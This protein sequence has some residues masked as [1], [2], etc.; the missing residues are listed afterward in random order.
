MIKKIKS[1]KT[2]THFVL[3]IMY[4]IGIVCDFFG[5]LSIGI[6]VAAYL[7]LIGSCGFGIAISIIWYNN[8]TRLLK[9]AKVQL[10]FIILS[11]IILFLS[12]YFRMIPT[13]IFTMIF[14][15]TILA[16]FIVTLSRIC[17]KYYEY[18]LKD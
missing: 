6:E 18:T 16:M 4:I 11:M 14:L 9:A 3:V 7:F 12:A 13:V 10:I 15:V 17:S 1:E 2:Q 5:Y 8:Q